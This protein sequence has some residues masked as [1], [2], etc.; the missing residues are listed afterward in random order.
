M[1]DEQQRRAL[2]PLNIDQQFGHR[3]L[4]RHVECRYGFIGNH[5]RRIAGEGARH[6]DPLLLSAGQ[7][8]RQPPGEFARQFDQV[9]QLEHT[10]A[11]LDL[12]APHA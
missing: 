11:D 12:V 3:G 1:T 9:Q 10:L 5:Q 2:P 4:H 6:R 7:L 8:L